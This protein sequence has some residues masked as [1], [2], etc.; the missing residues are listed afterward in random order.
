[1]TAEPRPPAVT[2]RGICKAFDGVRVLQDVDFDVLQGA[3]MAPASP[4][5]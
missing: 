1:M 4:P 5:S 3:A 2:M